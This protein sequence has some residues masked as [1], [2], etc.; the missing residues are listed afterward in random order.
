MNGQPNIIKQWIE[1]AE[2]DFRNA[3]HTLLMKEN[4][5]YETICFHAQQCVEKYI[6]ALLIHLKIDFPKIHD[7]GELILLVPPKSE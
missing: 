4:Y 7:I 6:K 5:P 2:N 3:E 1:K